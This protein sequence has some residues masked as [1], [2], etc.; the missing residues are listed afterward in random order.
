MNRQQVIDIARAAFGDM[1]SDD[2]RE[3]G[4]VFR[5]GQAVAK[6]AVHLA[7]RIDET[8]D[9]SD[10]VLF[11]GGL[12]HDC[13]KGGP[14]HAAAGADRAGELLAGQLSPQDVDAV[15]HLVA[16][17]NDRG[18]REHDVAVRI[19]QDA[20][21]L[22]H[23]GAQ[24]I[25]LAIYFAAAHDRDLRDTTAFYR[26][27]QADGYHAGARASLNF[28]VSRREFD[29]RVAITDA[30]YAELDHEN[31]GGLGSPPTAN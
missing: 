20:D 6:L 4:F 17:H 3:A 9:V 25:W 11:C 29:R 23:F 12:F 30:F 22:D 28:E 16:H 18:N 13:A 26:H 7:R 1:Q 19:L 8:L 24:N 2:G 10:D 5:H 27:E 21:V 14:K 31:A 15:A